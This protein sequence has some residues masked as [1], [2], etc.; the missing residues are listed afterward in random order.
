VRK[1][2]NA[3]T[4]FFNHDAFI[5]EVYPKNVESTRPTAMR[6]SARLSLVFALFGVFIAG[7]LV[8][9]QVQIAR[10][11]AY[12]QQRHLVAITLEAVRS[13]VQAQ[14]RQGRFIELGRNFG[15]LVRQ[16]DVATIVVRD[17]KGR[18]LVG[19]CDAD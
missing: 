4:H 10:Q 19:R 12:A 15:D 2:V 17:R 1:L 11:E 16:A 5:R 7:G 9:R 3:K 18:R 6:L 14:A 13:L 8:L